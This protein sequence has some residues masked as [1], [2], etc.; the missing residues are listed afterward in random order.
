MSKKI[1]REKTMESCPRQGRR[2]WGGVSDT[3]SVRYFVF[4]ERKEER[5]EVVLYC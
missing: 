5:K 1:E 2:G 3:G 4:R